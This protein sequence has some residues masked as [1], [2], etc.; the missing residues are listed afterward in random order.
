MNLEAPELGQVELWTGGDIKKFA[1]PH[2]PVTPVKHPC[3]EEMSP[4]HGK[5]AL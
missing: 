2:Q 5:T 3:Y 4:P 1:F